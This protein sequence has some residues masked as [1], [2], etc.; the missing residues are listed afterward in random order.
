MP[1][2]MIDTS[3]SR[4]EQDVLRLAMFTQRLDAAE[5]GYIDD[6]G[7]THPTWED[8]S[9]AHESYK[10]DAEVTLKVVSTLGYYPLSELLETPTTTVAEL[11]DF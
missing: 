4:R 6:D 10:H 1:K 3:D 8:A 9:A 11:T 5:N 2:L 7:V